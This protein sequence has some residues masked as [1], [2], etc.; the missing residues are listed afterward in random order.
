MP[1]PDALETRRAGSRV[2]GGPSGGASE[3]GSGEHY[4]QR[5]DG[6]G[7]RQSG[8]FKAYQCGPKHGEAP[9][10]ASI[11]QQHTFRRWAEPY[12]LGAFAVCDWPRKLY[13]YTI[14]HFVELRLRRSPA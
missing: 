5:Q 3:L 9:L 14:I 12:S 2:R 4:S 11:V 1:A 10:N 6:E 8:G 13:H 7:C